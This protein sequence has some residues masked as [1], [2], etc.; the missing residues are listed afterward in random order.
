MTTPTLDTSAVI[1]GV[2]NAVTETLSMITD[3]IPL[4]MTIF[5]ALWGIKKAIGFF[6]KAAN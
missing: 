6:K 2:S 3:L 5:A 4:A 1:A